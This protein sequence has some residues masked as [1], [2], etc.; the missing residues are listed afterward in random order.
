MN[1]GPHHSIRVDGA[2]L[3]ARIME[4]AKIGATTKGGS[5][6]QAL[7]DGD[8]AGRDLFVKWCKAAGLDVRVDQMGN[9]FAWRAG[10]GDS[11]LPVLAGSHLDTQPTGGKFDGVYGVLAALE[12]METLNDHGVETEAPL[13]VASW[14]N[15]EGARF[16]PA[17][18]GSGVFAGVFDLEQTWAVEDSSGK[19]LKDELERIEYL[20]NQAAEAFPI[21]ASFEVHIEQGPILESKARQVGIVTGVQG[22]RWYDIHLQGDEC[23]AGPTPMDQRR[24][25]FMALGPILES[26]YQMAREFSPWARVTFGDIKAEPGAR[27]TVPGR[28]SL[29][30]DLR[31][32]DADILDL[33]DERLKSVVHR[34]GRTVGVEGRVEEIWHM[35]VT[36]FDATCIAAVSRAVEMLGYSSM[37]MVSGAGHDSLYI[38]RVAPASMIFVPCENGLSHNE[39]E[40][41]APS[42]LEAGCNVLLH[43][44]LDM[45]Y[46]QV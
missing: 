43:A 10:S 37:E 14:T 44:M 36:S 38:S 9:L 11:L 41:A 28:V 45:A 29:S 40:N 32:H 1:R 24:D 23:H 12:V 22:L 33:M 3:W 46:G 16:V 5:N 26:S 30:V 42:D 15:E 19:C 35:P 31:H 21:R 20:G 27:N 2:R 39:A 25:P 8:R 13:I 6:R 18:M 7:T 34:C 4:M 17:M